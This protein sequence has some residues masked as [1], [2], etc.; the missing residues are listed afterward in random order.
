MSLDVGAPLNELSPQLRHLVRCTD[1]VAQRE[2]WRLRYTAYRSAGAIQEDPSETFCDEFDRQPNCRTYLLRS[3]RRAI[4][5]IRICRKLPN[6]LLPSETI[7]PAEVANKVPSEVATL[8]INRF[9]TDPGLDRGLGRIAALLFRAVIAEATVQQAAWLLAAVR[10]DHVWFY[11]Q[12]LE[13]SVMGEAKPYHGLR[14]EMFLMGVHFP[15]AWPS[16]AARFPAMNLS[17][18][19]IEQFTRQGV[20]RC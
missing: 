6:A 15:S 16:V 8:E 4:G 17:G 2:A 10:R 14:T 9:V 11:E 5:S 1:E 7:W 12:V 20:H 3:G 19:E 13:M 18:S